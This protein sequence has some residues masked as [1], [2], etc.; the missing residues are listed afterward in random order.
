MYVVN[1]S[2][3]VVNPNSSIE[4]KFCY[5]FNSIN[6]D[7]TKH[8]FKFE[9]FLIEAVQKDSDI[10]SLFEYYTKNKLQ[11]KGTIIKSGVVFNFGQSNS[12][13]QS[14]NNPN[15]ITPTINVNDNSAFGSNQF[16]NR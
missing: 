8:K 6:E 1:P 5:L 7:S 2:Y 16:D 12:I 15:F 3:C 11:V 9:G 4:I 14:Q 10:K 13:N